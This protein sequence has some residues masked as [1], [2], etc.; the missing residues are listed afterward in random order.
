MLWISY[1]STDAEIAIGEVHYG[2][3]IIFNIHGYAHGVMCVSSQY[4]S[5]F[6]SP[7]AVTA[8]WPEV[9]VMGQWPLFNLAQRTYV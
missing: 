6:A 9:T 7:D 3:G 5:G 4:I 8:I 1:S 2:L